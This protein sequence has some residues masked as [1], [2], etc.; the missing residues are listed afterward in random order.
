MKPPQTLAKAV[1]AEPKT[2]GWMV[3][4]ATRLGVSK[5][6][7]WQLSRSLT[8]KCE[9]CGARAKHPRCQRCGVAHRQRRRK[10]TGFP[11]HR[12][13]GLARKYRET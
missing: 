7:V 6:R 12:K 9:I 4:V 2:R 3:R 13:T 5:Q 8:G 1:A 10:A 11:V